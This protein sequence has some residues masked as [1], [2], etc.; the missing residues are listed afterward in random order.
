MEPPL[1]TTGIYLLRCSGNG[2]LYVGQSSNIEQRWLKHLSLLRADRPKTNRRLFRSAQKYGLSSMSIEILEVCGE[3]DLT[4]REQFWVNAIR[5]IHG[6]L[7]VNA[8]GPV[9]NP[10]RGTRLPI[11]ARAAISA[12]RTGNPMPS[13][14]GDAN[15]S[16]R[17]EMRARLRGDLNPARRPEVRKRMS[18]RNA[19]ARAVRDATTGE[20]WPTMS[21][22]AAA[23]GVSVAAVHAAATKKNPT[24]KGRT[25]ERAMGIERVATGVAR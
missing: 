23:L 3:L 1:M 12:R 22:C 25:L 20:T 5:T 17:P 19:M 9:D 4:E 6:G 13:I 18:E 8:V 14:R 7:L 11:E 16:R 10:T 24:A 15:P 2:Q 21:A